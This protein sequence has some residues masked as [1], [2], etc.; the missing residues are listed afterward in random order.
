MSRVLSASTPRS[1]TSRAAAS[2]ISS[3]R[4]RLRSCVGTR[5]FGVAWW[6]RTAGMRTSVG[7]EPEPDTD[8]RLSS[9]TGADM[10]SFPLTR[11]TLLG[12]AALGGLTVGTGALTGLDAADAPRRSALS[13]D[14]YAFAGGGGASPLLA[15]RKVARAGRRVLLVE[16]R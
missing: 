9:G 11:R 7:Y 2:R 3:T 16:A 14:R 4:R 10:T 12:G 15:A 8:S 6:V 1:T 5:R 13:G